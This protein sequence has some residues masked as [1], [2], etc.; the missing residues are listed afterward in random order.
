MPIKVGDMIKRLE[1]DGWLI[2][3]SHRIALITFSIQAN[4]GS[5]RWQA[6]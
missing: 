5:S 2:E 4:R 3:T 1:A 6:S